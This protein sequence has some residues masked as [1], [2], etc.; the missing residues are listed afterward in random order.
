MQEEVARVDAKLACKQDVQRCIDFLLS[1]TLP[2]ADPF[3]DTEK[4]LP[5]NPLSQLLGFFVSVTSILELT[6]SLFDC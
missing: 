2:F 3:N 5:E 6:S 1:N 4:V